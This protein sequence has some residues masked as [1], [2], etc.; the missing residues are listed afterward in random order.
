[1]ADHDLT[2][3]KLRIDALREHPSNPRIGNVD[4]IADSLREHGQYQPVVV[5]KA[6]GHVLV[7]NH[8]LK[9]A[10]SLGWTE[11]DAIELDVDDDRAK[12]ILLMDNKS[13]DDS[14]YD[15]AILL[16]VLEELPDLEGTG[17]DSTDLELLAFDLNDQ[18]PVE[19]PRA[20]ESNGGEASNAEQI[21]WGYIQ[22]GS[23]RVTLTAIEVE[24][25]N[26]LHDLFVEAESTDVG[27]GHAIA[28]GLDERLGV[29]SEPLAVERLNDASRILR[30][31]KRGRPEVDSATKFT[32]LHDLDAA[33]EDELPGEL[34]EG[35]F[36][37][38]GDL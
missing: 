1:M 11:I 23:R 18:E 36:D 8:R 15:N 6:T 26:A 28:D 5:Q 38:D 16:S 30:A 32:G 21:V 14:S 12:R 33:S 22:F 13:S 17:Y 19:M 37:E 9:A 31:G 35:D 2:V 7:G 25:L 34:V 29:D 27:W 20:V 24:R 10:R 3:S 4:L